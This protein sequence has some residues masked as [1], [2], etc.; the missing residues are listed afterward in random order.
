MGNIMD[1]VNRNRELLLLIFSII[2]VFVMVVSSVYIVFVPPREEL[3]LL[4]CIIVLTVIISGIF[5]LYFL[6]K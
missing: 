2:W 3:P 1:K 4:I 6:D 5:L